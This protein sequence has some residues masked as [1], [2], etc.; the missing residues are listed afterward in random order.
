[1]S[2]INKICKCCKLFVI[3]ECNR[4]TYSKSVTN[5]HL[6]PKTSTKGIYRR[7]FNPSRLNKLNITTFLR[8]SINPC[9]RPAQITQKIN[10]KMSQNYWKNM[11]HQNKTKKSNYFQHRCKAILHCTYIR[12]KIALY[13]YPA[14]V[15]REIVMYN[16]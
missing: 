7:S 10:D 2:N 5:L 13:I 16:D 12:M 1:M 8:S 6:Q 11:Q 4:Q 9:T 14:D 3:E 15:T